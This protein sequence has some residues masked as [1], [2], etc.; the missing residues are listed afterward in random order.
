[1]RWVLALLTA[2]SFEHGA[3]TTDGRG[4][5]SAIDARP[6]D[7]RIDAPIDASPMCIAQS[8]ATYLGHHYFETQNL[9][10]TLAQQTCST[11]GG[12]LVK[13][14]T[15]DENIFVMSTFPGAGYDWIGLSDPSN[16]DDY[17]WTDQTTL[18][19]TYNG[20][21]G[22]TPQS[23]TA[24]CVDTNATGWTAFSCTYSGHGGVCE[25]E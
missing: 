8:T 12:H 18:A 1:M 10:W 16:T 21:V 13:I 15:M 19:S 20:F 23:T 14:E 11:L 6:I 7:A 5:G 4:S 24:N 17:V 22:G 9:S 3:L 2:C 25:C